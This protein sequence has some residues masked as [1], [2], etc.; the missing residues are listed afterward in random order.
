MAPVAPAEAAS[1]A[2]L[3][4]GKSRIWLR[5]SLAGKVFAEGSLKD[6]FDSVVLH[7]PAKAGAYSV[8]VDFYPGPPAGTFFDLPSPW[9]QSITIIAGVDGPDRPPDPLAM[10]E[11]FQ[12]CFNFN[13][14]IADYGVREQF[15]APVLIGA[16]ALAAWSDGYGRRFDRENGLRINGMGFDAR[17]HG[18]RFS[19]LAKAY[20]ESVSGALISLRSASGDRY[21]TIGHDETGLWLLIPGEKGSQLLMLGKAL[22]RGYHDIEISFSVSADGGVAI[23]T[24][25][26]GK[27][28]Y[29][30]IGPLVAAWDELY[31]GGPDSLTAVF[32]GFGI[33]YDDVAPIPSLL[34]DSQYRRYGKNLIVAEGFEG[35][36]TGGFTLRGRAAAGLCSLNLDNGTSLAYSGFLP[37]ERA[38]ILTVTGVSGDFKISAE[39]DLG[40][41]LFSV[42][43]DGRVL[44]RTGA[45]RGDLKMKTGRMTIAVSPIADGLVLSGMDGSSVRIPE[46]LANS[47]KPVIQATETLTLDSVLMRWS[48]VAVSR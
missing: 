28:I 47:W 36:A 33:C 21:L 5:W 29:Q 14:E 40:A 11:R 44:D 10:P 13:D 2:I 25:D 34:A 22:D 38:V 19:I 39:S 20:F 1:A 3:D 7:V 37:M 9:S 41:V 45:K 23:W 16:P 6:E 42:S 12:S 32:D 15:Q 31:L 26:G 24:V 46:I 18:G 17:R 48:T 27:R 35:G 43:R 30:D 8:R 4:G